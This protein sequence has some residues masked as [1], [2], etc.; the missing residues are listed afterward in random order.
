MRNVICCMSIWA[1]TVLVGCG[2]TGALQL[3]SDPNYDKRAQYLLYKNNQ[4]KTQVEN[5]ARDQ[6]EQAIENKA[7]TVIHQPATSDITE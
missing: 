4:T 2:Q 1:T 5:Q 6:T 3:P 7:G